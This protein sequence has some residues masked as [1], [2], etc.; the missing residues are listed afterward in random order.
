[1]HGGTQAGQCGQVGTTLL[2]IDGIVYRVDHVTARR[3]MSKDID[4]EQTLST[5]KTCTITNTTLST[6]F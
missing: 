2:N 5:R 4:V 6:L 3:R 1:M